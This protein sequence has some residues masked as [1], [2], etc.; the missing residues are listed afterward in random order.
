VAKTAVIASMLG[1]GADVDAVLQVMCNGSGCVVKCSRDF[2]VCAVV[3][4]TSGRPLSG[5]GPLW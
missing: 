5:N 2:F 1:S 4:L 3:A